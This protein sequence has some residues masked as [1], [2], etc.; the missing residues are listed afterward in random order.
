MGFSDWTPQYTVNN[1]VMDEHHQTIF[2][3]VNQLH[4]AIFAKKAKESLGVIISSL[5]DYTERHFAEEERIMQ[6]H[7]YPGYLQHKAAHEH[8]SAQAQE[9]KL[10]YMAGDNTISS[11]LFYFLVSDLL[12][13]HILNMDKKY[14]PFLKNAPS[15]RAECMLQNASV[16]P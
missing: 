7:N 6:Q 14:A 3:M 1:P 8:L 9:F 13:K 16:Y 4:E 10:K 5:M 12:V 2:K 11:E 15:A